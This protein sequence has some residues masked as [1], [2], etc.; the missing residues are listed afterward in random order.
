MT[1]RFLPTAAIAA[2][3]AGAIFAAPASADI[4]RVVQLDVQYDASAL[5]TASGAETVL[6]SL[7]NQAQVACRYVRPVAGAPRVDDTCA[8]EVVAKAVIQI[9]DENLTRLHAA[10]FGE[11][12]QVLASLR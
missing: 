4:Q 9:G 7:Q 5:G 3:A 8:T 10:R 2:L 6:E 12:T 11:P 1:S